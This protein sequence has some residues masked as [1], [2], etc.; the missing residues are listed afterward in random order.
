MSASHHST[1][2]CRRAVQLTPSSDLL[3]NI[4]KSSFRGLG[5]LALSHCSTVSS[6]LSGCRL[7]QL[8]ACCKWL[9]KTI[10]RWTRNDGRSHPSCRHRGHPSPISPSFA[11]SRLLPLPYR[12]LHESFTFPAYGCET[13][14]CHLSFH[15]RGHPSHLS[16]S[17]TSDTLSSSSPPV[18]DC[19]S[20]PLEYSQEFGCT[21]SVMS[22]LRPS[23]FVLR[24]SSCFLLS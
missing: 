1:L 13:A 3:M 19:S 2:S 23:F 14:G 7:N 24:I 20:P 8:Y 6:P 21:I 17:P 4:P 10:G 12:L 15:D 22:R 18:G 5:H 16:L 11:L 9:M